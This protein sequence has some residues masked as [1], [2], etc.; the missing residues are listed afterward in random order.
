MHDDNAPRKKP[1]H[2]IGQDLSLLSVG[3]LRE[4]VETLRAEI[5][6][7]EETIAAKQVSKSAAEGVFKR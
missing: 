6:R 2:D 3:E 4:R 1:T 7:L 5:A